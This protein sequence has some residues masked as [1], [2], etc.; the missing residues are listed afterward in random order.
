MRLEFSLVSKS[1]RQREL[2]VV[3]DPS[4][5]LA[6]ALEPVVRPGDPVFDGGLALD[7]VV[8]LSR[9]QLRSGQRLTV[10]QPGAPGTEPW[11]LTGPALVVAAG[12][13][14]GLVIALRPG[15]F[16]IGRTA[17]DIVIPDATLSSRHAQLEVTRDAQVRLLDLG[18]TNGTFVAGR[19]IEGTRPTTLLPGE[20]L[21]FGRAICELRAPAAP[22][23]G[24]LS[25]DDGTWRFNRVLRYTTERPVARVSLPTA[26]EEDRPRSAWPQYLSSIA[27]LATGSAL[28]LTSGNWLYAGLGVIGPVITLGATWAVNRGGRQQSERRRHEAQRLAAEAAAQ[29]AAAATLDLESSWRD[30]LSPVDAHLAAIGPTKL[31]WSTD[32]TESRALALR[33][34]THD[35]PARVELTA[36]AGEQPPL[37]VGVPVSVDLRQ[38]PVFGIA[39]PADATS[40]LCRTLLMQAAAGRSPDDLS[41]YVLADDADRTRWSWLRWLPHVHRGPAQLHTLGMNPAA[42]R[43]RLAELTALLDARQNQRQLGGPALLLPEVLVVMLG[44]GTLRTHPAVVRLLQE[45]PAAGIRIIAVDDRPVRLPAEATARFTIDDATGTLEV[46]GTETIAGITPDLVPLEIAETCARALAPLQPLGSRLDSSGLPS[47]VRLTDLIGL[48]PEAGVAEVTARWLGSQETEGI[49]GVAEA[50]QRVV[51]NLVENG[52]HALVAGSTGSGKSEFLRTWIAAMALSANPT[53]L[54]FLLIDFKGGGAFGALKQL[55]HVVGYADDLTI[56]GSLANRLLDSLRAE[57]DYRK[58]R[59]KDAGHVGDLG[60]YRRQRGQNPQLPAIARLVIVV[61]EFAELKQEIPDFVDGLVNVAR[62]GRSLGVHLVL[63]TQQ[64]AGVVSG[65]I[66]DNANLRVCLRVLDPGTSVDLVGTP[67]AAGFSS[68][69]RGRAVVTVGADTTPIVFQ[70]AYVSA[71]PQRATMGEAPRPQ[72]SELPWSRCGV[73]DEQ[74]RRAEETS[75]IETDL[76]R[77]V[78]IIG[79]A[80]RSLGLPKARR[81]WLRPLAEV[82]TVEVFRELPPSVAGSLIPFAIADKPSEQKQV[83]VGLA[84]GGGNLGIAGGR[85]S[86]RSTA[87]RTIALMAAT[88]FPADALHLHVLDQTPAPALR[89][90]SALPHVGV[91]ATR[92]DRYLTERLLAR[93]LGELTDRARLMAR[94]GSHSFADLRATLGADAPPHILLLIDGWDTI[95]QDALDGRSTTRDSL[96]KLAEDGPPLGIQLVVGGQKSLTNPRL[97]S[98]FS[99]L[100]CLRF[101]QR[102]DLGHFDVPVRN[103]PDVLPPGRAYRSGSAD[104][105]QVAVC[106]DQPDAE[107]QVRVLQRLAAGLAPAERQVP[108]RITE[109]PTAITLTEARLVTGSTDVRDDVMVGVGGDVLTPHL[110][111]LAELATPFLVLGSA[112]SGRTEALVTICRQLLSQ[113]RPTWAYNVHDQDAARFDGARLVAAGTAAEL[114]DDVFLL[115]DN[116]GELDGGD[117]LLATATSRPRP[118][119]CLAGEEKSFGGLMGWKGA[120]RTGATGLVLS[121]SPYDGDLIGLKVGRDEAFSG[122]PGRALVNSRQGA[123]LIQVPLAGNG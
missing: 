93:L 106:S 119:L 84:L 95:V 1:G 51:L 98:T 113:G 91:V 115:V 34:G 10:G 78:G 80:G 7:P 28:S 31:L 55:P 32:A 22:E 39:G 33:L 88:R 30:T 65:Q 107:G 37:L 83:V 26:V 13:A 44:A 53:D 74:Q 25:L 121:P 20:R 47:S 18:S 118:R 19:R 64:P 109:L 40:G 23:D 9:G 101:E 87:F 110:I 45:A 61:D 111:R 14:A 50:N 36:S 46:R 114:P 54:S 79:D 59:F 120:L 67:V 81:P 103:I 102:D 76:T 11:P 71:P 48:G 99:E 90:L 117:A 108:L 43:A 94:R 100:L 24:S 2:L 63:A 60:G 49:V 116:A 21:M 89:P 17:A 27:M 16:V 104:A 105:I 97:N 96:L 15:K 66:R 70:A 57:L 122:P 123:R 35:R 72:V 3:A 4:L 112:G 52:P 42:L 56:G 82:L 41:L 75:G 68:T 6:Q 29:L 86:G 5:T 85:A 69:E 58:A 8:R 77:L 73:P 38:H 62:V 92:A 12:A